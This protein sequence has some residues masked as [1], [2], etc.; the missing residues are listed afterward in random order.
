M[1]PNRNLQLT[2]RRAARAVRNG[3]GAVRQVFD[4]SAEI[5]T[6]SQF[7]KTF[8]TEK[9]RATIKRVKIVA[10]RIG[11]KGFGEILVER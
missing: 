3:V 7:A 8:S 2:A 4:Y 1:K 5:M 9:E 11:K 6:P 10:P